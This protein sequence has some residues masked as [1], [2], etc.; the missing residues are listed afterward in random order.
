MA[1]EDAVAWRQSRI[2]VGEIDL[3][4]GGLELEDVQTLLDRAYFHEEADGNIVVSDGPKGKAI[5]RIIPCGHP[6]DLVAIDQ[7]CPIHETDSIACTDDD[8]REIKRAEAEEDD[9]IG[10]ASC[11]ERV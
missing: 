6:G 11:R 1:E 9:E 4:D 2:V 7:L 10:R 3:I 8:L 5:A